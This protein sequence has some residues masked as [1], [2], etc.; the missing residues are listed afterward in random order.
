MM[1]DAATAEISRSQIWQWIYS[2]KGI[3]DDGRKV[4]VELVNAIVAEEMTKL[5]AT[6]KLPF[7]KAAEVF[8]QI[9]TSPK[10][11]DFLTMPLYEQF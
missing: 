4:T 6:S 1:E 5:K 3:L 11:E 7:D 8:S 9:S 10:F 2:P